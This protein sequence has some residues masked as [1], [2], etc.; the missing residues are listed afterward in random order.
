MPATLQLVRQGFG[1]ELRRGT[2]HVLLDDND[3]AS[4]EW[5]QTIE[6]PVEP[7]HH[8]LHIKAG[9]YTSR[10]HPFDTADEEIVN[11]RC[12]GARIGPSTSRPS[13]SRTWQSRS[14]ASSQ[15]LRVV[16]G[17]GQGDDESGLCS[18]SQLACASPSGRA[19]PPSREGASLATGNERG[20]A[21]RPRR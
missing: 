9:R 17:I 14:N 7:G 15:R 18:L 10:R 8:I 12:N 13:S 4:I 16:I 20:D 3:V 2:F 11:F 1:I 5:N 19:A 21:R 6:V